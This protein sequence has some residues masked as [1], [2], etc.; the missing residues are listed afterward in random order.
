MLF[1]E[2]A[3]ADR[4]ILLLRTKTYHNPAVLARILL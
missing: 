4:A 2:W 1:A 3:P